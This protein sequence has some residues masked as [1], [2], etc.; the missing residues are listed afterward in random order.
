MCIGE[1]ADRIPML[2]RIFDR[3]VFAS[4]KRDPIVEKHVKAAFLDRTTNDINQLADLPLVSHLQLE[5]FALHR[6]EWQA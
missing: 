2:V 6:K 4:D 3:A 1:V 5:G